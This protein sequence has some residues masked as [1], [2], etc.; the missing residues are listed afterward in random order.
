MQ[1]RSTLPPNGFTLL[2]LL[3]VM[4]I[5][6]LL[7]TLGLGSFRS[8]QLKAR[9]ARRKNDL[10]QITNSLETYYNDRGAYPLNRVDFRIQGCGAVAAPSVCPWGDAF[11]DENQT[12]YMVKL[13]S[14][15]AGMSY[16][17]E[18]DGTYFQLYA[19]LENTLDTDLGIYT[20]KLCG[21]VTCNYGVSSSN[22][23]P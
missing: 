8:S 15:P 5:L 18:S 19:Y 23:T 13:P 20:G 16:H 2:E 17:Y 1:K 21:P 7:A 11:S 3:V 22:R 14:D 4:V 12:V 9:D 6:G 10:K